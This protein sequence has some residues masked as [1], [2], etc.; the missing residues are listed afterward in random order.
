M[1]TP[2]IETT[3][4]ALLLASGI[5][6]IRDFHEIAEGCA[7]PGQNCG[8]SNTG[9]NCCPPGEY[10]LLRNPWYYQC[11]SQPAKCG[12]PEVGVD[13]W[14]NDIA[15]IASLTLPEECCNRCADTLGCTAFTFVNAGWD[16]KTHCY[17]K[18]GVD[19]KK[20]IAGA[21]SAVVTSTRVS[22]CSTQIGGYCG[23]KNWSICCPYG[24]YCQPWST[25]YYQ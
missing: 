18:S 12:V 14:G 21:V 9:P 4:F 20:S 24:S 10:C 3:A 11:V 13:Y 25:G 23:N 17:L 6:A 22:S 7:G 16:G 15:E 19:T 1:Q 8:N 2:R 5:H